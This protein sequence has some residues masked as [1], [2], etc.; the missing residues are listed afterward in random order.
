MSGLFPSP[1]TVLQQFPKKPGAL[2]HLFTLHAPRHAAHATPRDHEQSILASFTE[3]WSSEHTCTK[4]V[5]QRHKSHMKS[6]ADTARSEECYPEQ[7]W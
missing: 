2:T 4:P 3:F 5:P 6:T 7:C 1:Y